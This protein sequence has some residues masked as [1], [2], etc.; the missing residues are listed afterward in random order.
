MKIFNVM[1]SKVNGGLEQVF[2][3]Y[4]PALAMQGNHVIP[5]I[6]PKAEILSSC[7]QEHLITLHNFNQ[8]DFIAIYKLRKL[9]Q[10]E[11]PD[12]II[13]HSYRAAYLAQK[14]LTKVPRIAVCHVKGHYDFGS[15]A[16]IAITEHMRQDIIASGK[17]EHTVFTVPNMLHI[18]EHL[19]YKAPRNVDVPVIGACARLVDVKGIDLFIEA[20]AE[21]QRRGI[22]FKAKIAG[23]GKEKERYQQ[24]IHQHQLEDKVILLGWIED[25]YSFY[26]SLDIFCLP[27]REEAFGM[28]ILESM[29][30]SLPM[31]LSD[32]SGPREIIDNSESA[33]LV[34]P[35]DPVSMADAIKQIIDDRHLAER[36]AKN[37]YQRVQ[38]YSS[39]NVGPVL[40]EVLHK[41]LASVPSS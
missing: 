41:I 7:P 27:S 19:V 15:D 5:I 21:L 29:I 6:H 1:F 17:P 13:T 2:L 35:R 37:A 25:R 32:L 38:H 28:V 10:K 39:S 18:P 9:I 34:T 20:L 40:Q 22:L 36:L 31:V 12:C 30:H 8:H 3:N 33:L 24:L 26:E 4:I 11:Q 14:T 23:D 16:I